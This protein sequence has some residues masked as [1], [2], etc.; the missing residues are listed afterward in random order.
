MTPKK[1]AGGLLDIEK[2]FTFYAAY[3]DNALNKW[4]HIFCIWPLLFTALILLWKIPV[5]LLQ[6]AILPPAVAAKLSV[7]SVQLTVNWA[8]VGAVIYILFYLSLEAKNTQ[9]MTGL[10]VFAALLVG[11]LYF[12]AGYVS[13]LPPIYIPHGKG[14]EINV[15]HAVMAIHVMCWI[16]QFVGHFVFEGRA[17]ALMT[18]LYQAFLMAP[19]FVLMEMVFL[20]GGKKKLYKSIAAKVKEELAAFE[21]QKAISSGAGRVTRSKSKRA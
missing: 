15:T 6:N 8:L 20:A 18:N 14:I 10:G 1:D 12:V 11:A 3:H 7:H 5:G 19:I 9:K 4:I 2:Q 21:I 17:P 13:S 16:A